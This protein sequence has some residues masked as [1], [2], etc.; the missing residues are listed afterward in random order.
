LV[1]EEIDESAFWL[2]YITDKQIM[3]EKVVTPLF[4]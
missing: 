2:E 3:K 1:L 4:N